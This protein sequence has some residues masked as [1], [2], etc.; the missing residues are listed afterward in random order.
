M[1]DYLHQQ[2]LAALDDHL[3]SFAWLGSCRPLMA[4]TLADA[5]YIQKDYLNSRKIHV[6][7]A[8]PAWASGSDLSPQLVGLTW[9]AVEQMTTAGYL[10][11]LLPDG[12]E[13]VT[14]CLDEM[15]IVAIFLEVRSPLQCSSH[16]EV[17]NGDVITFTLGGSTERIRGIVWNRK[18]NY[19]YA[20]EKLV[21]TTNN[22][23][24][25]LA[26]VEQIAYTPD[27]AGDGFLRHWWA[28][29]PD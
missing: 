9:L 11:T 13:P 23:D 1:A 25:R 20:P 15:T 17:G 26:D 19:G 28:N 14:H 22:L 8:L 10:V 4:C 6:H 16:N 5:L 18:L 27:K 29:R 7:F 2:Q 21:R 3:H 24:Y 12:E